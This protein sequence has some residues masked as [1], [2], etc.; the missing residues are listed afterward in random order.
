[1]EYTREMLTACRSYLK[2]NITI[3]EFKAWREEV[4]G[5]TPKCRRR[6]TEDAI[7]SALERAYQLVTA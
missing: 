5:K 2:G 6:E 4:E 1:M 7:D 3:A